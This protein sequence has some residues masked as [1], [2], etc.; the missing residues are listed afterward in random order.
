MQDQIIA[1]IKES[2]AVK[3]TVLE[4]LVPSI[5]K[6]AKIMIEALRNGNK[7]M[8]FGN[9]GSAADSQHFAGELIGRFLKERASLPAIALTTDSSILTALSNDYSFDI[10]FSR[11][12]EGLAQKGDVAFG[13]ST[14]GNSPNVLLGIEKA[15]QYECKTISLLGSGG[16]KI[17]GICDVPIVILK[18]AT[19]RIQESHIMIG[20]ILCNLI[21][22][23]LFKDE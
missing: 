15:K 19:P 16:G 12:I 10:V 7:I 11:Q 22:Q 6:A 9:G 20:H 13:I 23:E 18:K 14:S 2:I 8:F 4:E 3:Q 17:A 5:E 21:E 1:E